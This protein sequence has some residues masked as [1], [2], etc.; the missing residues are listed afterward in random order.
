MWIGIIGKSSF[1]GNQLPHVQM[2]RALQDY[3]FVATVYLSPG[4]Q[5]CQGWGN[6][7]R[8]S[9]TSTGTGYRRDSSMSMRGPSI[10]AWSDSYMYNR[11][12]IIESSEIK[13]RKEHTP[14]TSFKMYVQS[15]FHSF[16]SRLKQPV[17]LSD[18]AL[19][20]AAK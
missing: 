4:D 15:S 17:C 1:Y 6:V 13:N 20:P 9:Q 12:H 2:H 10:I 19:S 7:C 8:H 5:G 14:N 16:L 3:S 18:R 11:K